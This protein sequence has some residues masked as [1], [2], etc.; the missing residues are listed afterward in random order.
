M[1]FCA[2]EAFEVQETR[3]NK[4]CT[5][6]IHFIQSRFGTCKAQS[7]YPLNNGKH[8][9]FSIEVQ[10]HLCLAILFVEESCALQV[11]NRDW[12]KMD[13]SRTR[14]V[15]FRF[16]PSDCHAKV[17]PKKSN[18]LQLCKFQRKE[19]WGER[20]SWREGKSVPMPPGPWL[21]RSEKMMFVCFE[22]EKA[23]SCNLEAE[24]VSFCP[25]F[26]LYMS[27]P[28]SGSFV[29]SS[30]QQ[31]KNQHTIG[32]GQK[33]E[34][35][36]LHCASKFKQSGKSQH[37]TPIWHFPP[38]AGEKIQFSKSEIQS[39]SIKLRNSMSLPNGVACKKNF[40]LFEEIL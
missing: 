1:L 5:V 11:P 39:S 17:R 12:E 32:C 7:S 20:K 16:F 25:P 27:W 40:S 3:Q 10:T 36:P 38:A 2:S 4:T 33:R 6:K 9:C 23:T 29:L 21:L 19:W 24:W 15:P 18:L 14:S 30:W 37:N 31:C 22:Q 26:N 35:S 28:S 13:F 34:R 8:T